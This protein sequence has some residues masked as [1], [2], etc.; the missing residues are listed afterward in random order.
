MKCSKTT[1]N[2]IVFSNH[3]ITNK[4]LSWYIIL[5]DSFIYQVSC[6]KY[7]KYRGNVKKSKKLSV[8]MFKQDHNK[9][10]FLMIYE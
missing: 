8:W 9:T 3:K 10:F 2:V 1:I 7:I 5:S 4:L 6:I